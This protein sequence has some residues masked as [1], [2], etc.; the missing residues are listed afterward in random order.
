MRLKNS[1]HECSTFLVLITDNSLHHKYVVRLHVW[2]H[3]QCYKRR[4]PD[5]HYFDWQG[6]LTKKLKVQNLQSNLD[7][8]SVNGA[9]AACV[10]MSSWLLALL[11][12]NHLNAWIHLYL[13]ENTIYNSVWEK[14]K[15]NKCKQRVCSFP[16]CFTVYG[17]WFDGIVIWHSWFIT[18]LTVLLR[19]WLNLLIE[20]DFAITW[21]V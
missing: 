1:L 2:N 15:Q 20:P 5:T 7:K 19:K 17:L 11:L 8:V 4:S 12:Y 6:Y 16:S 10:G 13:L 18:K 14:N 21:G 3:C 9:L